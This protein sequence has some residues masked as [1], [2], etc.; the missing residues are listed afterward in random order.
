MGV[1]MSIKNL[2]VLIPVLVLLFLTACG[3]SSTPN[4]G[5][6]FSNA[7]LNGPYFAA[8]LD[9][10]G[11]FISEFGDGTFD[12]KG[13]GTFA[14]LYSDSFRANQ[15]ESDSGT[16]LVNVNGSF[17]I[18]GSAGST[19]KCGMSANTNTAVCATV[20]NN[21]F[22]NI[23]VLVIAG[24]GKYS[25]ASL[26]GT[27]YTASLDQYA[28]LTSELGTATFDGKGNGSFTGVYS[29]VSGASQPENE[30]GTYSVNVNGSFAITGSTGSTMKCG[31]SADTNTAVCSDVTDTGYQNISVLVKAG[32]GGY[33]NSSLNGTYYMTAG[34]SDSGFTSQFGNVTFNGQGGFTTFGTI[35]NPNGANQ[36][37]GNLGTYSVSAGGAFTVTPLG[38][39]G[40][41]CNMGAD[42]N[43]L[44]C[45]TVNN[46][47]DQNIAVLVKAT[48]TSTPGS[49]ATL[50]ALAVI[51]WAANVKA[52]T[53]QQFKAIGLYSD[54]TTADITSQVTWSS[55]SAS[56]ATISSSGL[57]KGVSAGS[58]NII[59]TSGSISGSTALT[60]L[61]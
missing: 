45:A 58:S 54:T 25:N 16:Y 6:S 9:Q 18:T 14:G 12:G 32:S 55:S 21:T 61:N 11:D 51:P 34:D 31:M 2:V 5:P 42:A 41:Q 50:T 60:V 47:G 48:S 52:G 17:T 38:G 24:S 36:P 44:L 3:G 37:T 39:G 20:N 46:T 8:S 7:S 40:M 29:N 15:T 33:S 22:Q 59:A 43:T 28:G 57:A 23:S 49:A 13:N 1:V 53:T 19:M 26:N 35:N 4:S 56:V 30:P 10:S 27:Y